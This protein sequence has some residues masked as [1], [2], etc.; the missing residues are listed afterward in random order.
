MIYYADD[1][2]SVREDMLHGFFAGWPHRP[3]AGQH[4]AVLRGSY[5][6]VVAID[7]AHGRVVGCGSVGRYR[8]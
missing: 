2:V 1:L 3:S 7:D 4:L 6:L 8:R 5:R